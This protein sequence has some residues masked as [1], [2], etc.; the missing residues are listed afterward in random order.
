MDEKTKI[1]ESKPR[2]LTVGYHYYESRR[3]D[4]W[5]GARQVPYLRLCGDWLNAAGFK[6]GQ[7]ARI[8]ATRNGLMILVDDQ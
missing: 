4:R 2:I 5:R 8:Q 1:V 7:K 6:I 3:K